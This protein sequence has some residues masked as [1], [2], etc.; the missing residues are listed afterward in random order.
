MFIYIES[1]LI[2]VFEILCCKIFFETFGKKKA[3]N[4][5]YKNFGIIFAL[6][7]YVYLIAI[8]FGNYFFLKQVLI[9]LMTAVLM[10][11]YIRL[12]FFKSLFLA[13]LFQGLL[14][15]ID[16]ITLW[17]NVEIFES[18]MEIDRTYYVQGSLFV[19]LGKV[20]LF[21][22]VLIIRK[23][24]IS[25]S[26]EFLTD[27]E[28]LRLMVFPI[29][30]I[31]SITA[32]MVTSGN[33]KNQ[34]QEDVLYAIAVCLAGINIIV[35]HLIN[36]I[37]KREKKIRESKIFELQVE[38]QTRMYRS[39]S[40]NFEKQRKKTHE[41]K[42]Q[43]MCI[44]SLI[45]KKNYDELEEYVKNISGHFNKELDS[46]NTNNVIVD[47]ILNSK[48]QETLEKN[49]AFIIKINDLSQ[50]NLEDEDIVVILSNLLNN[51]IEACEKCGGKRIIKVKFVME[52]DNIIISV[53][54]TYDGKVFFRD[55]EIQTLKKYEADEHGIGIKNIIETIAVYDGSYVIQNDENE[56]YFSIML[57]NKK[58]G[59][60]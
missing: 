1:F 28:W 39:V 23:L 24:M 51:A 2:V 7:V 20:I 36:D 3:E 14:L 38:N 46:I 34:N 49:I 16:Y 59:L 42:N 32:M 25:D 22:T 18:I 48:Y 21:M 54:N 55:G 47:A 60:G 9:I 52:D 10:R 12:S 30:T 45:A 53:K 5:T 26:S 6:I 27:T 13:V 58:V 43:I 41:Y 11:L 15:A 17:I 31:C 33:I 4:N 44:E 50:I 35:F 57:P 56:F 8:F 37:L 19:I 29:F 40:E